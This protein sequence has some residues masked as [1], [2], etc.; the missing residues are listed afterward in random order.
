MTLFSR[1]LIAFC[2]TWSIP[3][4][5]LTA[6]QSAGLEAAFA[7]RVVEGRAATHKTKT[8][9]GTQTVVEVRDAK[10]EPVAGAKV[11]FQLP[12]AG[13]GGTFAN[14]AHALSVETNSAGRAA[15]LGF[16]P[17]TDPG[18]F[19]VHIHVTHDGASQNLV[20]WQTNSNDPS[21]DGVIRSGSSRKWWLAGII[22]AG[23]VFGLV[24]A[25]RSGGTGDPGYQPGPPVVGAPR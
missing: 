23:A 15:T 14:G 21:G 20:V 13:P 12:K 17:N 19:P 25:A 9:T 10:G 18:S 24:M 2:L 16:T 4:G 7:A 5:C 3:T 22:G 6:N 1:R 8:R 11:L